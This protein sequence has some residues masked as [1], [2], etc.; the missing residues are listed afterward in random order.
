MP[1]IITTAAAGTGG[2][3]GGRPACDVLT[4]DPHIS[5]V[6]GVGNLVVAAGARSVTLNVIAGDVSVVINGDAAVLVPAGM[7]LS[8]GI[9][10]CTQA[11]ADSFTFTNDGGSDDFVVNWTT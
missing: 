11:L 8:W 7:S 3:G 6:T 1:A 2:G 9:D 4:V 5:R 10:D